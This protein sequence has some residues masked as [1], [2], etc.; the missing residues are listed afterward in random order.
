MLCVS[1]HATRVRPRTAP[2]RAVVAAPRCARA[3]AALARQWVERRYSRAPEC[4]ERGRTPSEAWRR[5]SRGP[6]DAWAPAGGAGASRGGRSGGRAC[7]RRVGKRQR[8]KRRYSRAPE[9]VLRGRTADKGS[10]WG[11]RPLCAR[12][13]ELRSRCCITMLP[14]APQRKLEPCAMRGFA[15]KQRTPAEKSCAKIRGLL[16]QIPVR[17]G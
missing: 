7:T 5:V 1:G 8:V 10:G 12:I 11:A 17:R 13:A 6:C 9:C 3:R 14:N 2:E 16:N 15:R 4:A